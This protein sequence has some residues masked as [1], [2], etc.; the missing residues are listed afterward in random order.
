M[1]RA[2][3]FRDSSFRAR[4][5]LGLAVLLPAGF[6]FVTGNIWEDFFITFRSSL[7]LVHGH[8]LVYEVGR[9]VHVFTSPLGVLLPAGI[10]W[11]LRTDDPEVVMGVFRVAACLTL[12]GA[13]A[14]AAGRL[15]GAL[16]VGVTAA[17]WLLDAKL[18][19]YSTNG[20]ETAFLVFFVMLAWRALLDRRVWLSGLALAGLMWTRPDGFVFAGALLVAVTLI[21]GESRLGWRDW[22]RLIGL[23]F[24]LYAPWLIFAW[25]YYG[26]PVPNTILAKGQ[27]LLNVAILGKLLLYPWD[28][29]FGHGVA[30][31]AFMPPYFFFGGW[32]G[33]LWWQGKLLALAAATAA[34]WPRCARPARVAGAAFVL[35]GFY[36][37]LTP[38]A[39]WYFPAWQLLAYVAV[40]GVMMAAWQWPQLPRLGRLGL[41][42]TATGLVLVQAGLFVAVTVQLRAQQQVI[43]WGVRREVG[44]ELRRA[45]RSEKE[46]VFLEPLGYIG[47][48]S[49]LAMRDTPGLCAP[50]VVA[51]R[52]AGTK[53]MG[54]LIPALQ[55]DWVVLRASEYHAL[56][57]SQRD[58]LERDYQL[59]SIH[60]ARKQVEEI[61]WLPGRDYLLF[62]AYYA[63]WRRQSPA[64]RQ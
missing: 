29:V 18:A 53:S 33:Q 10:S 48:Y 45:A 7:N 44:L 15:Q 55:P 25:G 62:D 58:A 47:F 40:G 26:S 17:L 61:S 56:P 31:D 41:G 52:Q 59:W 46:T 1:S 21:P 3:L 60:D 51:L 27:Q 34:F 22:L 19:A 12:G 49:G 9:T 38:G 32:P 13:W 8:G 54:E 4:L 35:G 64:H 11:V 42:A 63:L 23:G 5:L 50:E 37:T 43:E 57:S 36:L 16:A 20:M 24:V 6:A 14:L 2:A 30:H 39:P 28:F